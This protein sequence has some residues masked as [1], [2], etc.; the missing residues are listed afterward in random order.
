M[1]EIKKMPTAD[2]VQYVN[3]FMNKKHKIL[4]ANSAAWF[5][6]VHKTKVQ[7]ETPVS[8]DVVT[9]VVIKFESSGIL[10]CV[11]LVNSFDVLK[12]CSASSPGSSSP[13]YVILF[14]YLDPEEV[15]TA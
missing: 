3:N 10:H 2:Q 11:D 9:T 7:G 4:K 13:R 6:E 15:G 5:N 8:Y 12:E 14:G 1:Y